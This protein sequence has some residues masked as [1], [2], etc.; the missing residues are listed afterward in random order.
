MVQLFLMQ[1]SLTFNA[2][3]YFLFF[4]IVIVPWAYLSQKKYK[5]SEGV[6]IL[7]LAMELL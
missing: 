5:V 6:T 4:Q 7:V 3:I 1:F 2:S